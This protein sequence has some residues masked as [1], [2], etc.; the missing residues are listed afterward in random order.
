MQVGCQT[1]PPMELEESGVRAMVAG[2]DL[3]CD[4]PPIHTQDQ[5]ISAAEA[6]LRS[7]GFVVA[8]HRRVLEEPAVVSGRLGGTG[9]LQEAKVLVRSYVSAIRVMVSIEPWGND[10]EGRMILR[11]LLG[12]LGYS[13]ETRGPRAEPPLFRAH[14]DRS[15]VWN[16]AVPGGQ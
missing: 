1:R 11:G 8:S 2:G 9:S 3:W 6:S 4:L 14:E 7:R 15:E 5:L 12:R 16:S 10:A 13:A